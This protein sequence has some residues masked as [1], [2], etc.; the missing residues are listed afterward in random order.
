QAEE[1]KRERLGKKRSGPPRWEDVSNSDPWYDGRSPAHAYTIVDSPHE[2]T[3][4][5]LREIL[6]ILQEGKWL[7][8]G[9]A[10]SREEEEFG[11][12]DLRWLQ[13]KTRSHLAL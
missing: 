13:P 9:R 6:E 1:A 3:V 10:G 7:E 12:L 2:G 11:R 5:D 8:T 4:L